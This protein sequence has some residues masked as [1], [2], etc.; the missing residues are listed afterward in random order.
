MSALDGGRARPG[1][2]PNSVPKA[3]MALRIIPGSSFYTSVEGSVKVRVGGTYLPLPG[4]EVRLRWYRYI[5][6]TRRACYYADD[7]TREV[8]PPD[9]FGPGNSTSSEKDPG[10]P[11]QIHCGT[12][13]LPP[14]RQDVERTVRTDANGIYSIRLPYS[15]RTTGIKRVLV[16]KSPNRFVIQRSTNLRSP[17]SDRTAYYVGGYGVKRSF[18]IFDA[19]IKDILI[20]E[21][22]AIANKAAIAYLAAY[23][24]YCGDILGMRHR[25]PSGRE[26]AHPYSREY[27]IRITS[28]H[29]FAPSGVH[30]KV[31]STTNGCRARYP[32]IIVD[33]DVGGSS[34]FYALVMHELAH[35]A[36]CRRIGYENT[37]ARRKLI[38]SWAKTVEVLLTRNVDKTFLGTSLSFNETYT[39]FGIDLVDPSGANWVGG[40]WLPPKMTDG[41]DKVQLPSPGLRKCEHALETS[42]TFEGWRNEIIR[43]YVG[44]NR[45]M[46]DRVNLLYNCWNNHRGPARRLAGARVAYRPGGCTAD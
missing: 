9:D 38:E 15:L 37:E 3:R 4:V 23:T 46:K 12:I 44:N 2:N 26:A 14:R 28:D 6:V 7:Y 41:I 45:T 8:L 20:G 13:T 21:G 27:P 31:A 22:N 18:S 17:R 11:R 29:S 42:L 1:N 39:G 35:A 24:Y 33:Q 34:N 10:G 40:E 32:S 19:D 25:P 36:H 16:F 43:L 5:T 30:C